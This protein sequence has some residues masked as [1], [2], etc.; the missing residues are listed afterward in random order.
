MVRTLLKIIIVLGLV[1]SAGSLILFTKA[2]MYPLIENPYL[3]LG[4]LVA[5]IAIVCYI[6]LG[7]VFI[8]ALACPVTAKQ[9]LLSWLSLCLIFLAFL[10]LPVGYILAG[11]F[12][13]NFG[14]TDT[15]QGSNLAGVIYRNFTIGLLITAPLYWLITLFINRREQ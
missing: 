13:A 8:N 12:A 15:F 6:S 5:A 2:I 11:D 10:W 1:I 7:H 3:P 9:K 4:N 14:P